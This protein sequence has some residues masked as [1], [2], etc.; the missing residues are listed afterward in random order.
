MKEQQIQPSNQEKFK[1]PVQ[2]RSIELANLGIR[3]AVSLHS[4]LGPFLFAPEYVTTVPL[5]VV[6][7]IG[8]LVEMNTDTFAHFVSR[9]TEG[10]RLAY[11]H[12]V[13]PQRGM[14]EPFFQ[15]DMVAINQQLLTDAPLLEPSEIVQQLKQTIFEFEPNLAMYELI[16][17]FGGA[18]ALG[19]NFRADLDILR[20]RHGKP[21]AILAPTKEKFAAVLFTEFGVHDSQEVSP[22]TLRQIVQ[23]SS[24][25]DTVLGPDDF[26]NH[27][28]ERNGDCDFLLYVR[29]SDPVAKLKDPTTT[30]DEPLLGDDQIRM[31]I[32]RNA[33]TLIID[34]PEWGMTDPRRIKDSKVALPL[35]G[36]GQSIRTA[37]HLHLLDSG[38]GLLR[39][40][41]RAGV[42]GAY[43]Q[44]IIDGKNEAHRAWLGE[45]I[46]KRGP[47]I[48]QPEMEPTM[49]VDP[50]TA[51]RF[52]A[53]DRMFFSMVSG[54]STFMGGIRILI[55][56][57]SSNA[58]NGRLHGSDDMI[59]AP[60]V[61][62]T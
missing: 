25:F 4:A 60:I 30:V 49:I 16:Q 21:I 23:E 46:Q 37:N 9:N 47:Y 56:V 34:N 10:D 58:R 40:K 24:G 61:A 13:V 50:A 2:P 57:E 8:E 55:P 17:T 44:K 38:S 59:S 27:L 14:V 5:P 45:K 28:N 11:Q 42:F 41:P 26:I 33:I 39:A 54:R 51:E 20:Q 36:M 1:I 22:E 53:M 62:V 12:T 48:V 6:N 43:G 3:E 32:R 29:P 18:G 19:R 15:V 52:L 31:I 35:L 7:A